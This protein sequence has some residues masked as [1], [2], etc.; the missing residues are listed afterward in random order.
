MPGGLHILEMKLE[1][2]QLIAKTLSRPAPSKLDLEVLMVWAVDEAASLT[3]ADLAGPA[4]YGR[5]TMTVADSCL[6]PIT[7]SGNAGQLAAQKGTQEPP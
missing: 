4:P 6:T 3:P 7:P 5:R 2:A 1:Y